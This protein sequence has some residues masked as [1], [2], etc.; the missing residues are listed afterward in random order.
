MTNNK[1]IKKI[2]IANRGEIAIRVINSCRI[3]GI[4]T[5]TI[6]MDS[7]KD[8]P[9]AYL[10]DEAVC[11][12]DGPLSE[13]YLNQDLLFQIAKDT[14][15]DAIHPGYGFL[16]ENSIFRTRADKEGIIFIGPSAKAMDLMGS[17]KESKQAMEKVGIPLIPGYHGDDQ[18]P[19][20]LFNEAKKI[21]FPCLIKAS[22][23]GG[24]K[25]M[26]IVNAE[27]D[28]TEALA[29]AKSESMKAFSD[30]KVLIEKYI[31]N[32]RH[33]EVQVMSDRH[34]N[35]LHFF[36]RECSIQRRYQKV[37]EETPATVLDDKL[38][39]EICDTAVKIAASIK[40]EGAGTVEFIFAPDK[41]FYFLEMNT[42]LQVEHPITEMVTGCDLV[43]LQISV[44]S[45]EK[46]TIK[47]EDIKQTGHSIECRIYAENPDN[48]FLPSVGVI[49]EVGTT[50][51]PGVRLDSGFVNG[52]EVTVNFDPMLA[53]LI[54]HAQ[55][56]ASAITK[57]NLAL[58]D[59]IFS[60]FIT[61]RDYLRRV[62]NHAKFLS[63]DTLTSF[64][65]TYKD[66]LQ[67]VALNDQDKVLALVGHML[68][69]TTKVTTA[70]TSTTS[71]WDKLT[72][73]RNV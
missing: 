61:N 8:Y 48:D 29:A 30:D 59:F 60:G 27:G 1:K 14:G 21:G 54:V 41:S 51:L 73:F 39:H 38:R 7:E 3:K 34:G 67:A 53:K 11:L 18:D 62:I 36:E 56:R 15:A 57:M 50:T 70:A 44:A 26:R 17:K 45:G 5:V 72:S 6:Y 10:S 2:L 43:D 42:R 40:Y 9:H 20:L 66:D 24:G 28:F 19:V 25:G 49:K 63:G 35:H 52:N 64:V 12:G 13:T 16:S 46:L 65:E 32:P 22:A 4:K 55:D 58:D 69:E 37:V 68:R 33:I 23:G 31:N 71:A 47:Q